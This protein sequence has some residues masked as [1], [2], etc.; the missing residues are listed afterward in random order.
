MQVTDSSGV[1][2]LRWG[3]HPVKNK[4]VGQLVMDTAT[5][6]TRDYADLRKEWQTWSEY[7][8]VEL[9]P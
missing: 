5:A 7:L 3:T 9:A 6:M 1:E 8:A 4:T 2:G